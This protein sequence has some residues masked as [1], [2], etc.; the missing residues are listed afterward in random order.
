MKVTE[1][2][3]ALKV[4]AFEP[5]EFILRQSIWLHWWQFRASVSSPSNLRH[6]AGGCLCSSVHAACPALFPVRAELDRIA[7]MCLPG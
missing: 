4:M 6:L 7:G 5:V 1:E 2:I 3:D